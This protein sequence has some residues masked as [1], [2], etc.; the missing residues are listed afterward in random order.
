MGSNVNLLHQRLQMVAPEAP[1]LIPE[2]LLCTFRKLCNSLSLYL[3]RLPA[4]V[5]RTFSIGF[6]G[7]PNSLQ[8]R[9]SALEDQISQVSQTA[10]NRFVQSR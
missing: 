2:S 6:G 9:D 5:L 10:F 7:I 3:N 1:V 8:L 4:S